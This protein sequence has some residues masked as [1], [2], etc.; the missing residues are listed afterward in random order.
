MVLINFTKRQ[1]EAIQMIGM[2][3]IVII[4]FFTAYQ[5]INPGIG[6]TFFIGALIWGAI[7]CESDETLDSVLANKFCKKSVSSSTS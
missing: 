7:F 1:K 6:M 2:A 4:G 5:T 3:L